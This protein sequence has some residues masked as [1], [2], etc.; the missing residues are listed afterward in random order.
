MFGE[1]DFPGENLSAVLAVIL[2]AAK[3]LCVRRARPF[4]AL[5]VTGIL[6]KCLASYQGFST[7]ALIGSKP[8]PHINTGR[9]AGGARS[10]PTGN[11]PFYS[12][13]GWGGEEEKDCSQADLVM[14]A[15]EG[16]PTV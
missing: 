11:T 10:R 13:L 1:K 2:S 12:F 5:R 3:D 9:V 6:S 7:V 4:A 8:P 15:R 14:C 16:S